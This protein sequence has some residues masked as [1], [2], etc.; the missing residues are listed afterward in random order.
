MEHVSTRDLQQFE[1]PNFPLNSPRV[2]VYLVW[3][4]FC[5]CVPATA[6]VRVVIEGRGAVLW[7]KDVQCKNVLL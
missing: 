4:P 7:R 2:T 6:S 3:G 1:A 5:T